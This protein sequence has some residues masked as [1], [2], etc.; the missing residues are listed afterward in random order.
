MYPPCRGSNHASWAMG[1]PCLATTPEMV[2]L[3]RMAICAP[4]PVNNLNHSEER[5]R[6]EEVKTI[7]EKILPSVWGIMIFRKPLTPPPPRGVGAA[8]RARVRLALQHGKAVV[9]HHQLLATPL[10]PA[11][12]GKGG[13]TC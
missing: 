2:I 13:V 3:M 8:N 12:G 7:G 1:S 9:D 5:Q 11:R 6:P 10:P 4:P